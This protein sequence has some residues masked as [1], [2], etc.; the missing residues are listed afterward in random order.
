MK[1]LIVGGGGREHALAWKIAQSPL[2]TE[3]LCAPGNAG[4]SGLA[5]NISVGAEDVDG[6]VGLAKQEAVGLVV[7]GPEAP[8]AAGLADALTKEGIQTFGPSQQA[9]ALESSKVFAKEF[10]ERH[11]IPTAPFRVFTTH[12]EAAAYVREVGAP[13]VVKAEG[14]AAGKGVVVASTVE[15]ALEAVERIMGR[16]EFGD[17]GARV[18]IETCLMGREVS[19]IALTDGTSVLP[20]ETAQDHKRLLD[21]DEGPNTGG[22]G[23]FSP[24]P[25]VSESL[26]AKILEKVLRPTV[27]GMASA[28]TPIVGALYAGLM[29]VDDEPFVLEFNIRFGDPETQPL[30]TRLK[31]DLV[32]LLQKC[33]AGELAGAELEW[34][35]R[36]SCCVVLAAGGYPGSYEKGLEI[37]GLDEAGQLEDVVVFHAGTRADGSAVRTAGGRV[38]GVSALGQDLAQAS[39]KAYAAVG[40][41]SWE[42]AQY[43]RDIG[44]SA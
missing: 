2:V 14:L 35:S 40:R 8:L 9:A 20:L 30:L 15:E 43:R 10:M 38:L 28:G 22:M 13:I 41:I 39:D 31:S 23:A 3:V 44:R 16:R 24:A 4:T 17:A 6:L 11:A 26:K 36:A 18:V 29:I 42:G 7:V 1:V 12:G 27:E 33:A 21:G 25:D 5:R 37:R 19:L 34:D 32:P